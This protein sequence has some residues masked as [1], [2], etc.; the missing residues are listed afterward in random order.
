MLLLITVN[1]S[2]LSS[3]LDWS[4]VFSVLN[5][6][7]KNLLNMCHQTA[8]SQN[9]YYFNY[10]L[11]ILTGKLGTFYFGLIFFQK[12]NKITLSI[13]ILFR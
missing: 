4:S 8:F 10:S 2:F 9:I 3:S 12:L 13:Q 7:Y 1:G 11:I 6:S 5:E